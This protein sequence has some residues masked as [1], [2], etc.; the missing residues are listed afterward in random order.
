MKP[1]P[2]SACGSAYGSWEAI[3]D[4]PVAELAEKIEPSNF[5]EAKAPNIKEALRRIIAERGEPSID[6][7]PTCRRRKGWSG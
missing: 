1:W 3:R 4:A 2:L 6:F 5:P 7:L